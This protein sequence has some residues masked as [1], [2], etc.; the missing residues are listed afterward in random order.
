MLKA[1]PDVCRSCRRLCTIHQVSLSF[2]TLPSQ[3]HCQFSTLLHTHLVSLP[4]QSGS[5]T[6]L[7]PLPQQS[8]GA[9][10]ALISVPVCALPYSLLDRIN[11]DKARIPDKACPKE[12]AA[13]STGDEQRMHPEV[14]QPFPCCASGSDMAAS[15]EPIFSSFKLA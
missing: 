14:H 6:K 13:P 2:P 7:S 9:R 15:M 3:A 11:R 12:P 4:Q 5:L 1:L 8:D 10:H